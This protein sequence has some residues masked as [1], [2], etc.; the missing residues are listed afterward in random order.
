MSLRNK[1]RVKEDSGE[2]AAEAPFE[3]VGKLSFKG[4]PLVL[5]VLLVL[6]LVLGYFSLSTR[7]DA[8]LANINYMTEE[9]RKDMQ[10]FQQ[11][12][13]DE[14]NDLESVYVVSKGS[15][16]DEAL[17]FHSAIQDSLASLVH[18]AKGERL[19]SCTRFFC[20]KDEQLERLSLWH[21]F[22]DTHRNSFSMSSERR[23]A[24]KV[25]LKRRLCRI[26]I[27]YVLIMREPCRIKPV[28]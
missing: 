15:S 23:V 14:D 27:F 8:N 5:L 3:W 19:Y 20:S 28:Y 2:K 4:S 18:P 16:F 26:L 7:F 21:Q 10:Y 17:S 22:I 13:S 6:T 9:Q 24:R 11:L 1:V 25:L 12:A